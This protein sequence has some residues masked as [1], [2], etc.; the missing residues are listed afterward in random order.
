[1]IDSF[2]IYLADSGERGQGPGC[3][4]GGDQFGGAGLE[5]VSERD[6]VHDL[7]HTV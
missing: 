1:M 6:P 3:A 5:V 7:H 4:D 2:V